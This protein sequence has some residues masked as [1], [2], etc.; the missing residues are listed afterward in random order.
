MFEQPEIVDAEF[1]EPSEEAPVG[2]LVQDDSTGEPTRP[3]VTEDE[4]KAQNDR[5]F[6]VVRSIL[7]LIGDANLPMGQI[8]DEFKTAYNKLT[9]DVIDKMLESDIL[10]IERHH[11]FNLM[12]QITGFLQQKT[13]TRLE[14]NKDM[15][16][17]KKIGKYS[18]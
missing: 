13:L 10:Y 11:I 2:G 4:T 8:D 5:C 9:D 1:K 14:T 6:P 17:K 7:K 18:R 12:T 15:Y 16:L 3:P